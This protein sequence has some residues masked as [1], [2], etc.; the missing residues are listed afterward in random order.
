MPTGAWSEDA[1][2]PRAEQLSFVLH[3]G[4]F[5]Y[6]SSNTPK[7]GATD[8]SRPAFDRKAVR[9]QTARR[10]A[11]FHFP[12]RSGGSSHG[13]Q[14]LPQDPDLQDARARWPFVPVWDNHEFSWK[15]FRVKRKFSTIRREG[16][17]LKIA[18]SQANGTNISRRAS[19]SR[20]WRPFDAAGGR[21]TPLSD[22][23]ARRRSREP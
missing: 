22:L 6:G 5:I 1:R 7:M 20:P 2:R 12:D 10:S 9:Y 15:G 8:G 3:L 4:D 13:L 17:R 11:N 14:Q 21:N 16:R 23:D 18:A 19:S